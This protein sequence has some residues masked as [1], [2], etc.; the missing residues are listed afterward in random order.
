MFVTR[1]TF[2]GIT[3][4]CGTFGINFA[5]MLTIL[6]YY[7]DS[8][9][10]MVR[11]SENL[12]V[13]ND[14]ALR[15]LMIWTHALLMISCLLVSMNWF[16]GILQQLISYTAVLLY[17]FMISEVTKDIYM[18]PTIDILAMNIDSLV[19]LMFLIF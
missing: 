14:T 3:Q 16:E 12:E 11:E 13:L 2:R 9:A 1:I 17:I 7:P 10:Q 18:Q 8:S 5:M 15:K 4:I 6:L 19:R